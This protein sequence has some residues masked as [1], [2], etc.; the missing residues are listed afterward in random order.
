MSEIKNSLEKIALVRS[1]SIF[2]KRDQCS[3]TRFDK[4]PRLRFY[5]KNFHVFFFF[6]Q[7]AAI[8]ELE[9]IRF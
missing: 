5:K 8:E 2:G 1:G 7:S 4:F 3:K 9:H 6:L